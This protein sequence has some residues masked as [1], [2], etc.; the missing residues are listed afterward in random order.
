MTIMMI[1]NEWMNDVLVDN[2]NVIDM[3]K[4]I[5][6]FIIDIDIDIDLGW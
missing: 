2:M 1:M 6:S 5:T 3:C 4:F